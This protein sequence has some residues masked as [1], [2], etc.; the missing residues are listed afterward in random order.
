MSLHNDEFVSFRVQENI[1]RREKGVGQFFYDSFPHN[2]TKTPPQPRIKRTGKTDNSLLEESF[3]RRNIQL[4]KYAL[5]RRNLE[6]REIINQL[7][8][9]IGFW[10]NTATNLPL[11]DFDFLMKIFRLCNEFWIFNRIQVTGRKRVSGKAVL[12][13]I[14]IS[15]LKAAAFIYIY[16]ITFT[17][18]NNLYVL[19]LVWIFTFYS[20]I[21]LFINFFSF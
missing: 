10:R 20:L 5:R 19:I 7:K 16:K 3:P 15:S 8:I 6:N 2:G 14:Y 17:L 18:F 12:A 1:K 9:A 11:K 21:T 4:G 13:F